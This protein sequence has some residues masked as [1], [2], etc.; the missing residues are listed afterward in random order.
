MHS[1]IA[2]PD[3]DA[4]EETRQLF[5]QVCDSL[6]PEK[7]RIDSDPFDVVPIDEAVENAVN[8]AEQQVSA[9]FRR[10]RL[11]RETTLIMAVSQAEVAAAMVIAHLYEL[12]PKKLDSSEY[13]FSLAELKDLGSLDDAKELLIERR[14]GDVTR[15][16][17]LD[18]I[19]TIKQESGISAGYVEA[20]RDDLEEIGLRRNLLVHADG[21]INRVYDKKAKGTNKA[22]GVLGSY[23][24]VPMPY[25]SQVLDLIETSFLL[26][27]AEAWSKTAGK[28]A[29]EEIS[30]L[31]VDAAYDF[32]KS[33][34]WDAAET[35][36]QFVMGDK[37]TPDHLKLMARFNYWQA[38]KWSGRFDKDREDVKDFDCRALGAPF[39]L[40]R[41]ALLDDAVGFF[42]LLESVLGSGALA[43]WQVEEWPIF[44][45]MRK[46]AQYTKTLVPYKKK[47]G[48]V[49]SL[50]ET[51]LAKIMLLRDERNIARQTTQSDETKGGG[52]SNS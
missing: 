17:I 49:T 4:E 38:R 47:R 16:S 24:G 13:R 21:Y 39:A 19:D 11:V 3:S 50:T 8:H 7:L 33:E 18:W 9:V 26:L 15:G 32:L 46:D 6:N 37:H 2:N 25:L 27:I 42:P 43:V 22:G 35:L 14:V 23:V 30:D 29:H 31:L 45:D 40:G 48:E 41:A 12:Y 20:R 1:F 5:A 36:S 10:M 51:Q 34:R 52:R 44:R 28:E